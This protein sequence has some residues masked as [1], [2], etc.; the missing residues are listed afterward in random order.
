MPVICISY[1]LT[2][3]PVPPHRFYP[4]VSTL[5]LFESAKY[6]HFALKLLIQLS[7]VVQN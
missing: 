1:Q 4:Y 2:F 6:G 7:R 3:D 5:N